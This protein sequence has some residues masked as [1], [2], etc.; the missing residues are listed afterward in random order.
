MDFKICY[1]PAS[2]N[3]KLEILSSRSES[4][5]RTRGSEEPPIQIV[6]HEKHFGKQIKSL[7][8]K[9]DYTE[10]QVVIAA[11][12]LPFRRWVNWDKNFLEEVKEEV[13]KDVDYTETMK[14]VEKNEEN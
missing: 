2:Q 10:E 5:P 9:T 3:G 4:H 8:T 7:D 12:K 14:S 6:L 1:H 11:M 13:L